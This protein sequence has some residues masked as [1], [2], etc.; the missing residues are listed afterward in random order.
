MASFDYQLSFGKGRAIGANMNT[1]LNGLLGGWELSGILTFIKGFPIAPT[2]SSG[3]LWDP[4][5]RPNLIGDPSMLGSALDRMNNYFNVNS[6]SRPTTDTLGT[7]ART[8]NYR[9]PGIANGDLTVMKN[10]ALAEHKSFQF[11]LEAYNF[12]NTPTFGAPNA[13][14]GGTSFGIISGYAGGRGVRTVQVGG[15][16]LLLIRFAHA[17]S[18][19]TT[20]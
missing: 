10:F 2:L 19:R 12:T 13:S 4:N 9:A 16:V 11:R 3:T 1:I 7:A 5:Q 18:S 20:K 8:L 17:D 14:H 15:E 6:F